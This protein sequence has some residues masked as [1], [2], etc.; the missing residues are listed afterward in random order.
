MVLCVRF[1]G[2][3]RLPFLT[4]A[5]F[6]VI[7]NECWL[8]T[9]CAITATWE[10][11]LLGPLVTRNGERIKFLTT[12]IFYCRLLFYRSILIHQESVVELTSLVFIVPRLY[13]RKLILILRKGINY[14]QLV[15]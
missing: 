8:N 10:S 6:S 13:F 11:G 7:P 2:V 14:K 4:F 3:I 12:Y 15:Y 9:C 5:Q 1:T